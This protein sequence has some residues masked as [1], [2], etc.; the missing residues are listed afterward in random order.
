MQK[1]NNSSNRRITTTV[2]V[3]DVPPPFVADNE[4]KASKSDNIHDGTTELTKVFICFK[5][6]KSNLFSQR[7]LFEGLV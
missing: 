7:K 4:G 2:E 1:G 3:V 5:L 6:P